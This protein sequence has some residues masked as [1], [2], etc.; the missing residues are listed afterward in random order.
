MDEIGEMF[1][2]RPR[3]RGRGR[4]DIEPSNDQNAHVIVT[5]DAR[6]LSITC[7]RLRARPI[8]ALMKGR[9]YVIDQLNGAF[10]Q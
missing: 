3:R 1:P 9:R 7:A 4:D 10:E 6:A 5:T 8:D 2:I